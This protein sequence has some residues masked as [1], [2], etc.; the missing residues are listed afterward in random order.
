MTVIKRFT[1]IFKADLHGVLDCIEEP[2][3][4]VKQAIRD[5]EAIIA[6]KSDQLQALELEAK[7]V[8]RKV[9]EQLKNQV[10]FQEKIN[11]AFSASDDV[12]AKTFIKKKLAS[13]KLLLAISSRSQQIKEEKETLCKE[14]SEKQTELTAIEEKLKIFASNTDTDS[15]ESTSVVLDEEVEIAFIK[16]KRDFSDVEKEEAA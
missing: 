10:Q 7:R 9:E 2:E 3:A 6:K 1:R 16:M 5:M 15:S 12:L 8:Q 13:E 4:I 14:I 11:L